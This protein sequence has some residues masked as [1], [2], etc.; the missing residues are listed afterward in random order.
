MNE[1]YAIGEHRGRWW[2]AREEEATTGTLSVSQEE[3]I[4]EIDSPF[5][6]IPGESQFWNIP[7]LVGKLFSGEEITLHDCRQISS[8][9]RK[10]SQYQ[11]F[12]AFFGALLPLPG[13]RRFKWAKLNLSHLTAWSNMHGFDYTTETNAEGRKKDI[14]TF[15]IPNNIK[16]QLEDDTVEIANELYSHFETRNT[17]QQTKYRHT[18]VLYIDT[19]EEFSIQELYSR[20]F[21]PIQNLLTVAT[22]VNTSI[23]KIEVSVNDRDLVDVFF[24]SYLRVVHDDSHNLI[25][26]SQMPFNLDDISKNI[27]D[28]FKKW[29]ELCGERRPITDLYFGVRYAKFIYLEQKFLNLTQTA[30]S[31]HRMSND[32]DKKV[33]S[34]TE[35]V[36]MVSSSVSSLAGK[37][38]N[39]IE[40][41][42]KYG[43]EPSFRTR[44]KELISYTADVMNPIMGSRST[45]INDV[46]N[47]RNYYTHYDDALKEQVEKNIDLIELNMKLDI[48]LQALFLSE[49]GISGPEAAERFK[50]NRFNAYNVLLG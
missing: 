9:S 3:I 16:V 26:W 22:G 4:L 36:E 37:K 5:S 30:E 8:S 18:V 33:Y 40:M 45:F 44:L 1:E 32:Y 2:L 19:Q 27:E 25:H 23:T 49:I 34:D 42:L 10:T 21:L 38:R 13:M 11:V 24:P 12:G 47:A 15:T 29:L 41:K 39:Y 31:F 14:Q 50:R 7:T 35:Y 46:V 17:H 6:E 43:N 20:Y 48:L 28:I